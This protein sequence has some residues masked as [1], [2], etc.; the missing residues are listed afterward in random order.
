MLDKLRSIIG[1]SDRWAR[2]LERIESDELVK[3]SA[4]A[5]DAFSDTQITQSGISD[6]A[7]LFGWTQPPHR[8]SNDLL[9][10]YVV[11]PH[12]RALVER[13]SEAFGAVQWF[14]PGENG[15]RITDAPIINVIEHYN[16]QMI[17][18]V[19]RELEQTYLDTIGEFITIVAPGP[20]TDRPLELFPVLPTAVDIEAR[21]GVRVYVVQIGGRQWRFP[22][23]IVIHGRIVDP[24]DPYGRGRGKGW[25][26]GDEIETDEYVAKHTKN[27]FFNSAIPEFIG[28]L[29]G[30]S[31][32]ALKKFRTEFDQAHRGFRKHWRPA[33]V[34]S[35]VDIKELTQRLRSRDVVEIRRNGWKTF[36]IVYGV[37]PEIVGDVDNSNRATAQAAQDTMARYV[38]TPR[39][40]R[41]R[42]IWNATLGVIFGTKVD[43]VSPIPLDFGRRDEIMDRHAY[44]FTRNEIRQE[45]GLPPVSDDQNFYAVPVN[46]AMVP[47]DGSPVQTTASVEPRKLTADDPPLTIKLIGAELEH[48]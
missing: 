35:I 4:G 14:V 12:L 34:N 29:T 22:Q 31:D 32:A 6:G 16:D 36:K 17:G 47:A 10:A 9:K 3:L 43:F 45:A 5:L 26:L 44:H 13:V 27:Y 41:R 48:E 40:T 38:T 33:W 24:L 39:C 46:I 19:G 7:R 37:P 2:E 28:I 23:E 21:D 20:S 8:G 30:A 1:S 25:A 42:A 15:Q 11:S 18:S